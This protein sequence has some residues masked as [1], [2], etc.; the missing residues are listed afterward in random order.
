MSQLHPAASSKQ[1]AS[2]PSKWCETRETW[3]AA[4]SSS[5]QV[6]A[7]AATAAATAGALLAAT[8]PLRHNQVRAGPALSDL[9]GS[10]RGRCGGGN[11]GYG[12]RPPG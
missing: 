6:A 10:C 1:E 2:P 8:T 9:V 11:G 12:D 4:S 5:L 3:C 7:T